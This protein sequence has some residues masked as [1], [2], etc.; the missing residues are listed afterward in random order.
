M[1]G[2]QGVEAPRQVLAGELEA[3]EQQTGAV[4][5][6]LVGGDALDDLA[7]GSVHLGAVARRGQAEAAAGAA[8]IGVGDG[9][10][11]GMVVVAM[12]LAA[13]GGRAAAVAIFEEMRA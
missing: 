3:V 4:N 5:V 11:A 1:R 8:G 13:Q 9:H 6:K 12:A 7:E 2:W 10:S